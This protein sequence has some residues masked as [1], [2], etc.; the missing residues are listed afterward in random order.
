MEDLGIRNRI[1]EFSYRSRAIAYLEE[2]CD[3]A[4]FFD[5]YKAKYGCEPWI[6]EKHSN[7]DSFIRGLGKYY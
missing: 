7:S 4:L 2:D 5:A 3:M 6:F 1:S